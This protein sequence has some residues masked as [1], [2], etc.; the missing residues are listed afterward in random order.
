MEYSA[1]DWEALSPSPVVGVDEVGRGCLAG[2]VFAAA[3]IIKSPN[4]IQGITDSKKLSETRREALSQIILN[5]HSVGIGFATLQEIERWNILGATFIAMKRAIEQLK[6]SSGHILVDGSMKIPGLEGFAQTPLVKGDLRALPV[7][8][9]S[10]VAKVARD[11]MMKE[12][13]EELPQFGFSDHK[14]YGTK[15]HLEALRAQ[16]FTRFHR[17]QFAGV[18]EL[19]KECPCPEGTKRFESYVG[20]HL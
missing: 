12:L 4:Q 3:V 9:A 6:I 13:G 2:P 1:F 15:S 8:A 19:T 7:A 16:G 5:H 14:G 20:P 10:I 17:R 11:R 18:K